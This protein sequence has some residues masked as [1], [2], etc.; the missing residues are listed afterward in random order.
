M[1]SFIFFNG[2]KRKS[3]KITVIIFLGLNLISNS[4]ANPLLPPPML[5]EINFGTNGWSVEFYGGSYFWDTNL[6][7]CRIAGLYDTAQFR[8]GIEVNPDEV[9]VMT[10]DDFLTSFYINPVGD[11][12]KLEQL[13]NGQW[14][15]IDYYGLPFGDIPDQYFC[16][17]SAPEGGESIA[18][19]RFFYVDQS[20]YEG[21]WA[22]KELPATLGNNPF[23]VSKK[24]TFS[25][26]VK[27][28]NNEPLSGIKLDYANYIYYYIM[29][30]TVPEI[31]TDDN[32]Y[33]F[34]DNMFCKRYDINFLHEYGEIGDTT[35]FIEPDSA[36]Y[37]EFKLDTLL[38]GIHENKPEIPAYS[39]YTIPNPASFQTTFM[40]ESDNPK[41]YQKGVIKIYSEAGFIVD[42]VPI[43]IL[44]ESQEVIYNF[45]DKSLASGPYFYNLEIKNHK[46]ASGK[47]III[48]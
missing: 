22:V 45:N 3:V 44:D 26:Y 23:Q 2:I 9:L 24:T 6:D 11:F 16:E 38:T 8:P 14:L 12:L 28:S 40:I 35:V 33:F 1:N 4:S 43:E 32:G 46:V 27:D 7:S 29:T 5:T 19:Q 37:F 39:I 31:F 48:R 36:N 21:F 47:I 17:V 42:I 18:W 41:P 10:Q 30:P 20:Y 15:D 25:G 34:T 13:F